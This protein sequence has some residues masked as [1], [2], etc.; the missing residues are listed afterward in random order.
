[1]TRRLRPLLLSEGIRAE[2]L[3]AKIAPEHR[4][5]WY[6][7]KLQQ[8]MQVC[9]SHPRLV[10][11]GLDY[12]EYEGGRGSFFLK[13]VCSRFE[14]G[15]SDG[16][17]FARFRGITV[18]SRI[19][20]QP[21][22]AR[23]ALRTSAAISSIWLRGKEMAASNA[24]NL[25]NQN[26]PAPAVM[27]R[28]PSVPFTPGVVRNLVEQDAIVEPRQLCSNLLHKFILSPD[29]GEAPHILE[30]T[31]RKALHVARSVARRSMTL[32][33]QLSLCCLSRM[34]RPICQ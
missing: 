27:D 7:K 22:R 17:V 12:V 28:G 13:A 30:V 24:F 26:C 33:P 15:S 16:T 21:F 14:S 2:A 6:E 31:D 25:V 29:L 34:S 10:S 3:T 4:E 5:T 32:A 8:G 18:A 19:T 23:A 20:R 1:M 9:I 11:T